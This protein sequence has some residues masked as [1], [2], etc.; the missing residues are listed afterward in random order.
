[1]SSNNYDDTV[2][3]VHISHCCN[4]CGCKYR[5]ADCPVASGEISQGYSCYQCVD[6]H[7]SWLD[8][9]RTQ[10]L[11]MRMRLNGI[12]E[13]FTQ[14][15]SFVLTNNSNGK[16]IRVGILDSSLDYLLEDPAVC[17]DTVRKSFIAIANA[18]GFDVRVNKEN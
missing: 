5:D 9:P 11:I 4:T 15:P 18:M 1:M 16:L 6:R 14:I 8:D 12:P 3:G 13:Y 10:A 17:P 2:I 7:Q